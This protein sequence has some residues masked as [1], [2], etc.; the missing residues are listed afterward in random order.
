MKLTSRPATATNKPIAVIGSSPK[1]FPDNPAIDPPTAA[2]VETDVTAALASAI[3]CPVVSDIS[4]PKFLA[5]KNPD[6][7]KDQ[8]W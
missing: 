6:L 5:I 2:L 7:I 3:A 4:P 8:G 1:N